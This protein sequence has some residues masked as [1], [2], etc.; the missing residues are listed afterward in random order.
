MRLGIAVATAILAGT[1]ASAAV[2]SVAK[3]GNDAAAGTIEAPFRTISKAATVVRPGDTVNVRGGIYSERVI[4]YSKGTASAPIVFRAMAGEIV[5]LDGGTIPPNEPIVELT[6]TRHVD[7]SGFEVRN[8]RYIGIVLWHAR[9]TRVLGN[10]VHHTT[11]NGI[12]A[13]GATL[14]RSSDITVSNNSVHDTVLENQRHDMPSGGWA[15]AVVVSKT[16]RASINRNRIWNN[17]G[18][19]LISLLSD[20]AVIR[21][22]EIFD[23]FSAYLY[24][25]NARFVT[26]DRNLIYSTGNALYFRDGKPGAGIAIANETNPQMNRSRANVFTNNVVIGTRWGFYYGNYQSGGGLRD[27][28]VLH[29]TFSGTTEELV[30][31]EDGPHSN[32]MIT[33]NTF[34]QSGSRAAVVAGGGVTYRDNVW[35]RVVPESPPSRATSPAPAPLPFTRRPD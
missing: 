16:E 1:P 14:G 20:H 10:H 4:I 31:I 28:R 8:S 26:A 24:L 22:N 21:Y 32:N 7:F 15:G 6:G 17:H 3:S 18:E 13:G 5:I 11:R 23:N 30:R 27:T 19:G 35:S 9:H 33:N 29:N 34:L 12:Y 25:D 2:Y